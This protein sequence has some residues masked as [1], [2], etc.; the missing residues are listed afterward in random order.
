M[1][2]PLLA[3]HPAQLLHPLLPTG[4]TVG[5]QAGPGSG[6]AE[7]GPIFSPTGP[8]LKLS[9]LVGSGTHSVSLGTHDT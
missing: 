8:C 5:A 2:N 3:V 7:V 1:W 9:Q 6:S 4:D